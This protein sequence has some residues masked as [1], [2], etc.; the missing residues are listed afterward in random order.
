MPGKVLRVTDISVSVFGGMPA[1]FF[2]RQQV[3]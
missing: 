2:L 3:G 1:S